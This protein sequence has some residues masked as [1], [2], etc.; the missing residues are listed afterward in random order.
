MSKSDC[1]LGNLSFVKETKL[2]C[3]TNARG[4]FGII[5]N[6]VF[7]FCIL[8][9][10]YAHYTFFRSHDYGDNNMQQLCLAG[11]CN[12]VHLMNMLPNDSTK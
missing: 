11:G 1:S 2:T 7:H 3:S 10:E 4:S 5:R 8:C 9:E 6:E 12:R